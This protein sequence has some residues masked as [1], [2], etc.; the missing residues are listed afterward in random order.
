MFFLFCPE[1]QMVPVR[2]NQ[3]SIMVLIYMCWALVAEEPHR[4][5]TL[6]LEH[7]P[8]KV[9]VR[10]LIF[11]LH[12]GKMKDE[13]RTA[14]EWP[15]PLT[16][17][18]RATNEHTVPPSHSPPS[19]SPFTIDNRKSNARASRLSHLWPLLAVALYNS[20]RAAREGGI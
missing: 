5:T 1:P 19:L 17:D 7:C 4:P 14:H 8:L 2:Y 16:R 11:P 20:E 13:Q 3:C 18:S 10:C 12:L 15:L 6:N 9:N